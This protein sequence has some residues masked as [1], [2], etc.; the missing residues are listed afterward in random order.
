MAIHL[1]PDE[2]SAFI[3]AYAAI[4]KAGAVAV[5]TSTRLVA[6]EV[7]AVLSHAGAIAAVTGASTAPTLAEALP[8]VPT[9]RLVIP[10]GEWPGSATDGTV[11][12]VAADDA[13]IGRAHV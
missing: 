9:L 13:Q 1:P 8:S 6:R 10:T 2:A 7:A 4:H 11:D 3:I 12:V 5:P